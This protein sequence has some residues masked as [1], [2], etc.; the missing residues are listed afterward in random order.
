MIANIYNNTDGIS[1]AANYLITED[2]SSNSNYDSNFIDIL[3]ENQDSQNVCD[4]N[5]LIVNNNISNA[6]ANNK[7]NSIEIK[8]DCVTNTF[9]SDKDTID[10]KENTIDNTIDIGIL[11]NELAANDNIII[12]Y[13]KLMDN[14]NINQEMANNN[15]QM[16]DNS[17]L[18]N[19]IPDF[20]SLDL[21]TK[22]ISVSDNQLNSSSNLEIIEDSNLNSFLSNQLISTISKISSSDEEIKVD[23]I[24]T[25]NN[26]SENTESKVLDI[27][28]SSN[29]IYSDSIGENSDI[30]VIDNSKILNTINVEKKPENTE[31]KVSDNTNLTDAEILENIFVDNTQ[32]KNNRL[33][34]EV[35]SQNYAK[36][37]NYLHESVTNSE[38][39]C[40]SNKSGS[41]DDDERISGLKD[42]AIKSGRNE[43]STNIKKADSINSTLLS[44]KEIVEKISNSENLKI[45]F[46]KTVIQE[47]DKNI[48]K[49]ADKDKLE[50]HKF[51]ELS[52][53]SIDL[54]EQKQELSNNTENKQNVIGA[55]KENKT[56]LIANNTIVDNETQEELSSK[57]SGIDKQD[58][59]Q[60]GEQSQDGEELTNNNTDD[61]NNL[62]S[63][64]TETKIETKL[65]EDNTELVQSNPIL[66]K[67]TGTNINR[68]NNNPYISN[69]LSSSNLMQIRIE[70]FVKS[71]QQASQ[72]ISENQIYNARLIVRPDSLGMIFVDISLKDGKV[73][74]NMKADNQESLLSLEQ[75]LG[76]LKDKLNNQGVEVE[77]IEFGLKNNDQETGDNSRNNTSSQQKS[78][79]Y[80]QTRLA[81]I[82]SFASLKAN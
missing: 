82:R 53:D 23:I 40:I 70:E 54:S 67:T 5:I 28:K 8:D 76:S 60:T 64:K 31:T 65:R 41:K 80:Q 34:E 61:D 38:V 27:A 10:I 3:N 45:V 25:F 69:Q 68:T 20:C 49:N 19:I 15:N 29:T 75:Q 18:S 79:D 26:L 37:E 33:S 57:T 9:S 47:E 74:I 55:N 2:K 22:T 36:T 77:K 48:T 52:Q 63:N 73:S 78:M 59:E 12:L 50:I 66:N 11:T 43:M 32:A 16:V 1:P 71:T 30:N 81:Y 42:T 58:S 62:Q 51:N 21:L 4:N 35:K 13:D 6:L 46:S 7:T 14:I 44:E 56:E 72:N 39:V 17:Q 24:S